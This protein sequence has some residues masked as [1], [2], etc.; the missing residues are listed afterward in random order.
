MESL[1]LLLWLR[2][3]GTRI[4]GVLFCHP[5]VPTYFYFLCMN[6]ANTFL[7]FVHIAH[8]CIFT[9]FIITAFLQLLTLFVLYVWPIK[10]QICSLDHLWPVSQTI[11][12]LFDA[13]LRVV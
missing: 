12:V 2:H 5:G 6:S 13:V 4:A 3:S 7:T 8:I 9:Y 1:Y 11:R 10:K